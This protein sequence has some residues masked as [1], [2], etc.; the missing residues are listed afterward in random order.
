MRVCILGSVEVWERGR[1]IRPFAPQSCRL[2]AMLA[3]TPGQTVSTGRIA[4]YV[5][6][7]NVDGSTVRTAVSRLRKA[8][9]SSIATEQGGYRLVLGDDDELDA[10]VFAQLVDG[11]DWSYIQSEVDLQHWTYCN[12]ISTDGC[13]HSH[14]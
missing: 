4:E 3:A 13:L 9:G 6:G 10:A 11:V 12:K 14:Y 8:L 7:G 2:L 1:R 5:A